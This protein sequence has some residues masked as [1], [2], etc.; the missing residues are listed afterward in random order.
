MKLSEREIELISDIAK[1]RSKRKF[2]AWAGLITGMFLM[3]A[4]VY[5]DFNLDSIGPVLGIFLGVAVATLA[6]EYFGIRAE[7]ML[8]DLLQRYVNDDPDAIQQISGRLDSR[9]IAA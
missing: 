6:R 3:T 5:F 9:D 2:G 4:V 7:D 8:I 1:S